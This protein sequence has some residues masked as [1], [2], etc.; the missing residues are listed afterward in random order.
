MER[1]TSAAACRRGAAAFALALLGAAAAGHAQEQEIAP[2]RVTGVDGYASLRYLGD[3]FATSQNGVRTRQRIAEMREELFI[4]TH[5]YV[6]HPRFLSLDA[7]GGPVFQQGRHASELGDTSANASLYNLSTR[8][9]FLRDKPYFGSLFYDHLNPTVV[10]SPGSAMTQETTRYGFDLSLIEPVAVSVDGTHTATQG[11]GAERVVDD[12]IDQLSLRA[13]RPLGTGGLTEFRYQS[14]RQESMSGSPNLPLQQT[15]FDRRNAQLETR[16]R[17]GQRGQ[18]DLFNLVGLDRQAFG[19]SQQAVPERDERRFLVDLHGRNTDTVTTS[20]N[21]FRDAIDQDVLSSTLNAGSAGLTYA[22]TRELSLGLG[23][24]ADR[25]RTEQFSARSGGVDG[26]IQYR[27]PFLAPG[28]LA[29]SYSVRYTKREQNAAQPQASVAGE[30][31]S[32]SGT[33]PVALAQ[34]RVVAGSVTVSNLTR[35]QVFTE[36]IDYQLSVVGVTTRIQRVP[37]GNILDGQS[38]LVD[39]VHE[40]GGT[41]TFDQVDQTVNLGWS[42]GSYFSVYYRYLDSSPQ[43]MSGEPT[44]QLNTVRSNLYGSRADVPIGA[45]VVTMLGGLLEY[46]DRRE[47]IAPY[48][49]REI[50]AYVQTEEPV[51][52][53]GNMR[54]S[55]R[56]LNQDFDNS[57]QSVR[58]TGYELGLW[59][60][61]PLGLD[62]SANATWERDTGGP[63]ERTR[64]LASARS[65]WRYRRAVL[66]AE[67][68]RAKE[69]QGTFEHRRTLAQLL[70]RRDL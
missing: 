8:A 32:L 20:A 9:T 14:S 25:T 19:L 64:T 29:T 52:G 11:R 46:E 1:V 17:F 36:G 53:T 50:G 15:S 51:F 26:S 18:Y 59:T 61:H 49:R 69:A 37:G 6:Y 34:Q 44:T 57:P 28:T 35:T 41:F 66:T 65:Q 40:V 47:T 60:R 7:G 48:R 42:V 24:R 33:T 43:L 13:S 12:R 68:V 21:Y 38:V 31:V 10:V 62:L 63:V 27:R 3:E 70:F 23:A 67:L 30:T 58:L 16:L 5:S 2:F 39:Y 56:R 4:M 55:T 22:P 54:L 45:S